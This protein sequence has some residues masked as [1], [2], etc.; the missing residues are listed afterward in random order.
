VL[1]EALLAF[2]G[3]A[4]V[5]CPAELLQ[6][7]FPVLT[8]LHISMQTLLLTPAAAGWLPHEA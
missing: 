6:L 4:V 7:C 8:K 5:A 3:S 1:P 2:P